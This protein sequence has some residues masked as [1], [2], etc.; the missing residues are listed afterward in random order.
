[1]ATG[2]PDKMFNATLAFVLDKFDRNKS[3]EVFSTPAKV[4]FAISNATQYVISFLH[5]FFQGMSIAI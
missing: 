3:V 1:M 5:V 4:G 2:I